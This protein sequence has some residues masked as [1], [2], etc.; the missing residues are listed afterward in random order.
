MADLPS[1]DRSQRLRDLSD[2]MA[3]ESID[4]FYI[5][6]EISIRWISGFTGSS[7][8][9]LVSPNGTHLMT[10]SRYTDQATHELA[11][12]DIAVRVE[13][14]LEHLKFMK[15]ELRGVANLA[16]DPQRITW[17]EAQRLKAEFELALMPAPN[18]LSELRKIKDDSEIARIETAA[19]IADSALTQV[20]A[21]LAAEPTEVEFARLLD[22]KMLELGAASLSFETICAS[23]PNAALPHARPSSRVIT[24]GDPVVLDFGAVVDGY[25]SDMTRTFLIGDGSDELLRIMDLVTEAQAL[26]CE[27]I[28]PGVTASKVDYECRAHLG[29]ENL[30][31]HFLHGTGHGVGLEIH[32]APWINSRSQ[33]TLGANQV[34][35]CEPGVYL[36]GVG[37]VRVE[38]T[39]L[40]TQTGCRRLTKFPKVSVV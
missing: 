12:I 32:E 5:S 19:E 16:L 3:N 29:R 8:Q 7:G 18:L 37:G 6:D 27:A 21:E 11:G 23:G 13:S 31:Q 17:D 4:S 36:P 39:V 25:H 30:S 20:L 15:S 34:V 9:I 2:A 24:S 22:Y 35:T 26:G 38:D 33:D 1:I 10:D 14:P 40:I 28:K